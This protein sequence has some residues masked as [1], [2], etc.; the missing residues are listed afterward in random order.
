MN[1]IFPKILFVGRYDSYFRIYY[2]STKF[3]LIMHVQVI[4]R[5]IGIVKYISTEK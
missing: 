4:G 1:L 2:L 5:S 3:E